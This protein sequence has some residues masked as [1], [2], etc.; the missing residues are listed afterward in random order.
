M[1]I[2]LSI[3]VFLGISHSLMAV[4]VSNGADNFYQSKQVTIQKVSFNNLT[5]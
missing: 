3:I 2:I 5:N 1:K 4:D